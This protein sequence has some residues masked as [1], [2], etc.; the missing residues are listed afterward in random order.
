MRET[1]NKNKSA[2]TSVIFAAI[3]LSTQ[4][5]AA[6]ESA[7][8]STIQ[9]HAPTGTTFA[10]VIADFR[11]MAL[12]VPGWLADLV[13][14]TRSNVQ[15][16]GAA[17]PAAAASNIAFDA[18]IVTS[19]TAAGRVT[20]PP[21]DLRPRAPTSVFGSIAISFRRLPALDRMQ[22]SY[23]EMDASRYLDC[24]ATACGASRAA[25]DRDLAPVRDQGFLAKVEAVNTLVNAHVTYARDIDSYGVLDHWATPSQTLERGVGDCEDYAILKMAL[26]AEL[27]IPR[28]SMSVVVLS[29]DRRGLFHAVLAV[30]TN[31]G[32]YILDNLSDS[33]KVDS[34]IAHYSPLYS[35]SEG[36][37]FIHGRKA[38]SGGEAISR[39]SLD[40]VAP[41]EGPEADVVTSVRP[42]L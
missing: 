3:L 9:E 40:T 19:A 20:L 5:V 39:V 8:N 12:A 42:S 24:A 37:G 38:R 22:P 14:G 30:K 4:S 13:D 16:A 10:R 6:N 25:L 33:V 1:I 36:K 29:D 18:S 35:M 2:F 21:A 15:I 28:T 31:R 41:G 11:E 34:Q 23:V 26:L 7:R 27:G 17:Q 32:F